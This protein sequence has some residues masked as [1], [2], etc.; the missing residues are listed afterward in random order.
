MFYNERL[1]CRKLYIPLPHYNLSHL[2]PCAFITRARFPARFL[3]IVCLNQ[4]SDQFL[5]SFST[6]G[7]VSCYMYLVRVWGLTSFSTHA[8]FNNFLHFTAYVYGESLRS[9]KFST[10]ASP[11]SSYILLH[12]FMVRVQRVS[13]RNKSEVKGLPLLRKEKISPATWLVKPSSVWPQPNKVISVIVC[14][15]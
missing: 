1:V 7:L 8:S 5:P 10:H 15:T 11:K 2:L 9:H 6:R 12:M 4:V 3:P 13:L 14:L